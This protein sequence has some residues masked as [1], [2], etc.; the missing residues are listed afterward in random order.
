MT[1][2]SEKKFLPELIVID[3]ETALTNGVGSLEFYRDDFRAVSLAASWVTSDGSI[4]SKWLQGEEAQH[5]FLSNLARHRIPLA[6]HNLQFDLGVALCRF[7]DLDLNWTVDTM[8]LVQVYDNGGKV[9]RKQQDEFKSI[10]DLIEELETGSKPKTGLGLQSAASRLLPAKYHNHK[11]KYY[12]WIRAN[13]PGVKRGKEGMYLTQMP[14]DLQLSYNV[15]DTEIA[16][17]LYIHTTTRFESEKYDWRLDHQLY[18]HTLRDI[19]A[20]KIRGVPVDRALL[21]QNIESIRAELQ[22]IESQF[23][24]SVDAGIRAV[25]RDREAKFIDGPKTE[26]GRDNRRAKLSNPAIY[27][28]NVKFNVNSNKQLEDLFVGKLGMKPKFV[29][30]NGNPS[31]RS[32]VLHQWGDAGLIL[33]KRRKRLLVLK[34]SEA[35]YEL[36][37]YDGRWH[38]DLKAAGT[39]TSRFAGGSHG[40]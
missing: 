14:S 27:D 6:A 37:E 30:K 33:K 1:E 36:T 35:L 11:A 12:E 19:V 25:E 29:T 2:S 7:P 8:R 28:K 4:K 13:I 17:Q 32:A 20:N 23:R 22:D 3:F 21:L 18:L 5:K 9:A 38:L 10:D 26:R 16:L 34:Q 31:F 15:S 24:L 40:S 39:A